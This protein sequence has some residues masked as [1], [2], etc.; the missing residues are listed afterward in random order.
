MTKVLTLLA[1]GLATLSLPTSLP[2]FAGDAAPQNSMF[3]TPGK[4]P[5][6]EALA[7]KRN[8]RCA[9]LYGPGYG[10]FGDTDTCIRIGG[11]VGFSVGVGSFKQ[12]RLI[13]PSPGIG[14]P[15]PTLGGPAVGVVPSKPSVGTASGAAV[16][17]DTHTP[18]EYGDFATHTSVGGLKT[19]GSFRSGPDYVR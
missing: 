5:A 12:N 2:A 7:A 18:T 15:A 1:A 19:S 13:L 10:A 17:V 3:P 4:S 6:M 16:Y 11:S 9:A 14:A 8:A